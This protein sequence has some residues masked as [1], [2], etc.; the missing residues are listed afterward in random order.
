MET[1]ND[2]I[3]TVINR[4]QTVTELKY[5]D[6]DWSQLS[7][8]PPAVKYPCA[9]VDISSVSF[10]PVLLNSELSE[11][12]LYI[13]V[14][15][16]RLTPSSAASKR[17]NDSFITLDILEKIHAALH[18]FSSDVFSP[19]V[20]ESLEKETL[21]SSEEIYRLTYRTSYKVKPRQNTVKV[22]AKPVIGASL[23]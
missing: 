19:L 3:K 17:K 16:L 8:D 9:L 4:L 10:Q 12:N 18:L 7:Y 13:T 20:R 11:L 14:A 2:I 22:S 5:I 1:I 23:T 21:D 6:K 15:N